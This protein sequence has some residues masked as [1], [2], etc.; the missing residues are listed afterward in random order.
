MSKYLHVIKTKAYQNDSRLL[1][2]IEALRKQNQTSSVYI[3]EDANVPGEF[4]QDEMKITKS[5][6]YSRKFFKKGKGFIFKIPEFSWKSLR[7]IKRSKS[8]YIVFHD[9]QHYFT[10]FLL[11]LNKPKHKK[12][13]WDLHELFHESL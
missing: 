10:L 13:I 11:C 12:I 4:I 3:L 7:H 2:W 8:E 1:K 5:F 6:L 9:L